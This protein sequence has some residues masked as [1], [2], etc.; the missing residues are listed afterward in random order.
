MRH[1]LIGLA[2]LSSLA[3]GGCET[4]VEGSGGQPR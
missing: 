4:V 2:V 1:A 3:I